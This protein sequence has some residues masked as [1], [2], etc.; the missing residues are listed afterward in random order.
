[1]DPR[2][3]PQ[4]SQAIGSDDIET[5]ATLADLVELYDSTNTNERKAIS[6]RDFLSSVGVVRNVRTRLTIAQV[7]AGATLLPAVAG[8]KYRLVGAEAISVGGA[9]GAVTT[10]DILGT[11]ATSSVKLVAFAQAGLTQSAVLKAGGA[12]AAVLADGASFAPC[13]SGAAVTAGKT[14]SSVTTATHIDF[15][16]SFVLEKA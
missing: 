11:Q 9:A 13:D 4:G 5:S 1:M 6:L 12:N 3:Y 10:V 15:N 8:Y 2:M 14:G 7:N 16:V